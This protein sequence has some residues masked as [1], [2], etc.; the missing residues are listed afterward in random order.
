LQ[1]KRP[2]TAR[3]AVT[4]TAAPLTEALPLAERIHLALVSLSDGA[5]VFTGCD[6]CGSPL[7]GHGHAHILC[8]CCPTP[9]QGEH[10]EITHITVYALSGFGPQEQ[11][12]L[13]GLG[14]I[15]GPDDLEVELALQGLGRPEDFGDSPL[16]ARSRAWVS[17]TPF[18][19][20]RHPKSTRAGVAKV[21][22]TGLQIDSPEH[23][24]RRLL[25]LGGF[26]EPMAVE[27]VGGALLGGRE[28]AWESFSCRRSEGGG[29]RA[30]G[31]GCGFRVLF[32]EPVRGPVAV[33]YA[34]HF[35]MGGF[36]DGQE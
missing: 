13:Q 32:P 22:A 7:Q 27:P 2:T 20:T 28:V 15:W 23:E 1:Q 16:L 4:G 10:G 9:G 11:A 6:C 30:T 29:R 3:F 24:L 5:A 21:D 18:L 19:P 34:A 12:A 26:P 31:V 36:Y 17:R 35:G 14:R 8:E 33:G 25:G